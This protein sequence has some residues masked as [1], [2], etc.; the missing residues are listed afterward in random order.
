MVHLLTLSLDDNPFEDEE[1]RV[2]IKTEGS[3]AVVFS[4]NER[5]VYPCHPFSLFLPL[6]YLMCSLITLRR[7]KGSKSA[8]S[9]P[10]ISR[11]LSSVKEVPA[12]MNTVT[13]NSPKSPNKIYRARSKYD[14]SLVSF[15]HVLTIISRSHE[16]LAMTDPLARWSASLSKLAP[17][18]EETPARTSIPDLKSRRRHSGQFLVMP[19]QFLSSS[20]SIS[21]MSS[22]EAS[23]RAPSRESSRE[24]LNSSREMS[25]RSVSAN[26]SPPQSPPYLSPDLL[27]DPSNSPFQA[28]QFGPSSPQAPI[29]PSK[30]RTSSFSLRLTRTKSETGMYNTFIFFFSFFLFSFSNYACRGR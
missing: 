12:I 14:L 16:N 30:K 11:K 15:H 20:A 23:P 8:N 1:L 6:L 5:F 17:L 27:P 2:L 29:S 28:W 13:N 10:T 19:T 24:S 25:P 9:S 18:A 21:P 26:N 7:T 22:R 4:T 3:M